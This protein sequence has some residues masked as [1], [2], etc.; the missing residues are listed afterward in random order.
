MWVYGKKINNPYFNYPE[1]GVIEIR[2]LFT[3]DYRNKKG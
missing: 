3:K 1:F 2:E